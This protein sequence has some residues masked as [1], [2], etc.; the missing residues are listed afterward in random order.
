MTK[1]ALGVFFGII[2]ALLFLHI[3]RKYSMAKAAGQPFDLWSSLFGPSMGTTVVTPPVA[4]YVYENKKCYLSDGINK[5]EVDLL[6]CAANPQVALDLQAEYT[7]LANQISS[8]QNPN[9][10]NNAANIANWTNRQQEII[11]I[12][13]NLKGCNPRQG[14]DIP[15]LTCI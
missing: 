9:D 10:P 11:A 7:N 13:K 14:F 1:T 3:Y 15:T 6:K 12:L 5:S 8:L 4:S 2:G